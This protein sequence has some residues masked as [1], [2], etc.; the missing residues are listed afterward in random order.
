MSQH[1]T[2]FTE[3]YI[4]TASAKMGYSAVKYYDLK[5]YRTTQYKFDYTQMLDPKG[6]TAVYLF[7]NY[8]RICSIYKK[9]NMTE[10]EIQKLINTETIK[11]THPKEKALIAHILKFNDVIE[12]VFDDLSPNKLCDFVY[13]TATK[14]SEF[15]EECKI[16][17]DERMNSRLLI[18][19][20]TRR[21][22]KLGFDLLGLMP[23]EK[24]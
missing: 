4:E 21:F 24:I 23:V 6:N 1:K 12:E 2:E 14:F 15:Y 16:V 22:M 20:L 8:V 9:N 18:V 3:E 7:Y 10:E 17:G 19:E 11:I 13:G 5:Q